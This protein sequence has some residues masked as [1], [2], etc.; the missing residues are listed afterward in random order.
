ME[1]QEITDNNAGNC[2][3]D[4][5]IM[6]RFS[7]NKRSLLNFDPKSQ[8]KR[9]QD[10]LRILVF[11]NGPPAPRPRRSRRCNQLTPTNGEFLVSIS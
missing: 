9:T 8:M 10:A 4:E 7:P 11:L 1:T 6:R 3:T 5:I 2:Q